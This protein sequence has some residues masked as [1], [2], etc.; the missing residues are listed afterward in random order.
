MRSEVLQPSEPVE[1]NTVKVRT[2]TPDYSPT[3][4]HGR[5]LPLQPIAL[6]KHIV[7]LVSVDE[8]CDG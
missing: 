4:G 6:Y 8:M 3:G 1:P 2:V 7:D 5:M